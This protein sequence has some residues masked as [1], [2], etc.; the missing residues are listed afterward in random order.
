MKTYKITPSLHAAFH[1]HFKLEKPLAEFVDTLL[2]KPTE[3]NEAMQAGIDFEDAVEKCCETGLLPF[4]SVQNGYIENEDAGIIETHNDISEKENKYNDCVIEVAGIVKGGDWQAT[5]AKTVLMPSH[6]FKIRLTGRTDVV[7]KSKIADIKFVKQ[8]EIG[9]YQPS[10]QH[11]I[12]LYCTGM[13][14]FQYVASDGKDV[15]VE[16]YNYTSEQ[17]EDMIFPMVNEFLC[18]IK[19]TEF[20]GRNLMDIYKAKWEV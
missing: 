12:Y 14:K 11:L 1:W 9:K 18:F 3:T 7:C 6:G 4:G 2:R 13:D 15:Y 20:E 10:I 5:V 8:Y 16:E 17:L 19:N